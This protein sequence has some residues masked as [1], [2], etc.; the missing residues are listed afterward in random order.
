[1]GEGAMFVV[2]EGIDGSGKT[3][4][5]NR[6]AAALRARGLSVEHVREGGAFP[7]KVVGGIR[8]FTREMRNVEL[9]PEAE[10]LLYAAREAQLLREVTVPALA[11]AEVVIADRFVY[12]AEVLARHGR[13]L[14]AERVAPVVEAAAG[15]IEPALVVLVDVDPLI[16][17]IRRKVSKIVQP[18]PRPAS[19]KGLSGRGLQNRLREGYREMAARRGW[20]VVENTDR[21]LDET[22]RFVVERILAARGPARNEAASFASPPRSSDGRAGGVRSEADALERFVDW[23]DRR[24]AQEAPLA[25]ALL[26]GLAGPAVDARRERLAEVSPAVIANGI[27]GMTDP[28]SW[29]L[30]RALAERVPGAVARSLAGRAF[31]D[32]EAGR[33][34]GRLSAV[35]P[36]EVLHSIDGRDT[37]ESWALREGLFGAAPASAVG[38]LKRLAGGRAWAMRERWIA[39]RGGT[40]AMR[41]TLTATVAARSVTALDDDRAWEIR[42]LALEAA[43][44]ATIESL[45]GVASERSWALRRRFLEVAPKPVMRSLLG[46]DDPRATAL[47]ESVADC[48]PEALDSLAGLDGADAWRLRLSASERWPV[49]AAMSLGGLKTGAEGRA[50]VR[51]LLAAHPDEPLLW[52]AAAAIR[53]ADIRAELEAAIHFDDERPRVERPPAAIDAPLREERA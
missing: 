11:R 35:A 8:D 12:T 21:P 36:S 22:E 26:A 46:L 28:V 17:R 13:G 25:A 16:A 39:E 32:A 10:L 37:D 53:L 30:R 19:R 40:E 5:S 43:P 50:F 20:T 27:R 6:V 7:S 14:P 47:R 24:A 49:S 42:D 9:V 52:R 31:F 23:I 29:R 44:A 18:D 2:F 1:M 4:L 34:R 48:V 45:A 15:G 38:S 41:E 33:L 3:T 51:R